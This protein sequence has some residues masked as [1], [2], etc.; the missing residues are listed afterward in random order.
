MAKNY[1]LSRNGKVKLK[2]INPD[3]TGSISNKEE[4]QEDYLMLKEKLADLQD[5][6]IAGKKQSLLII[7][8]GMDCSGK[9]GVINKVL[10]SINP[11][12][13]QVTSFKKP[14]EEETSHD[15]LWRTHK[16][17]PAKGYIAAFNRSYYE[18]V[19]VT[20]VHGVI[21]DE[22]AERRFK[23]IRHFEKLLTDNGVHIVK[24]FLH[25]SKDFQIQKIK[26]RLENPDKRWKFDPSDLEERKSW[27]DYQSA[28]E[29][30]FNHCS[31]KYAPWYAVPANHR[32]F[33]DYIVLKI[34][35]KALED[36][37]LQYPEP[38]LE[39][40]QKISDMDLKND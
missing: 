39:L 19:L 5:K 26:D 35:V 10:S 33:R 36:M 25:I 3:D 14:T 28:Y 11:Q 18:D 24:I 16:A 4:I 12:G 32:W 21:D 20:R 29:D 13:F 6:L 37:D 34:V 8:Q 31:F 22:E 38:D 23:H 15:F 9:D 2:S 1:L 30:V 7:F 27:D 17:S 40:E